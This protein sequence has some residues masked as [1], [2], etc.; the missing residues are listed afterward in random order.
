MGSLC[1]LPSAQNV[2]PLETCL[3]EGEHA[4]SSYAACLSNATGT[5]HLS[6]RSLGL[7]IWFLVFS[8]FHGWENQGQSVDFP[9]LSPSLDY[10]LRTCMRGCSSLTARLVQ[11]TL[12]PCSGPLH[13]CLEASV[14]LRETRLSP[15]RGTPSEGCAGSRQV[16]WQALLSLLSQPLPW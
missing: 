15:Q 6:E 11:V 16:R 2:K 3:Q 9:Q 1:S 8:P 5:E 10:R 13:L 7:V 4:P 14:K 12:D